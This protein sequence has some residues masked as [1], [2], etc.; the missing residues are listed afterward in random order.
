M[1]NLAF[2][3]TVSPL[4]CWRVV[5]AEE[6]CGRT[7]R[8]ELASE[9]ARRRHGKLPDPVGKPRSHRQGDR[10]DDAIQLILIIMMAGIAPV[11]SAVGHQ[12]LGG[13]VDDGKI[14]RASCREKGC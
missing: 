9:G 1:E 6:T 3:N 11:L 10:L 4:K 7:E 14:G 13:I 8:Q 12:E 2:G 5:E